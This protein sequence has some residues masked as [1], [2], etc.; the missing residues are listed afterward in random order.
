ML[1]LVMTRICLLHGKE[2]FTYKSPES[3]SSYIQNLDQS[4]GSKVKEKL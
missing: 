2:S 1:V 4:L 3:E